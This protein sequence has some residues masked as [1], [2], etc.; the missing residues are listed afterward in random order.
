MAFEDPQL[1]LSSPPSPWSK[2]PP[3][4]DDLRASTTH[5][6]H[7]VFEEVFYMQYSLP[8]LFR[9][10]RCRTSR[11]L[12]TATSS[13]AAPTL[14]EVA[15]THGI[16]RKIDE[17]NVLVSFIQIRS[18]VPWPVLR[19]CFVDAIDREGSEA[20]SLLS[21]DPESDSASSDGDDPATTASVSG[22]G[23]QVLLE[24]GDVVVESHPQ[25]C[26]ACPTLQEYI[27]EDLLPDVLLV[28]ASKFSMY[29]IGCV[30]GW[31]EYLAKNTLRFTRVTLE[32]PD[33]PIPTSRPPRIATLSLD[34]ATALGSGHHSQVFLAPLILP[35]PMSATGPVSVTCK[36]AYDGDDGEYSAETHL[37]NEAAVFSAFPRSLQEDWSGL[38]SAK[39]D[40]RPEFM[41]AVVPKFYGYYKPS[42][43]PS[44]DHIS[45]RLAAWINSL[46]P[47]L[48]MEHCGTNICQSKFYPLTDAHKK[49]CLSLFVRLHAAGFIQ[50]SPY[51]RNITVQPGPLSLPPAARRLQTPSFRII[52]FGRGQHMDLETETWKVHGL[53]Y[54]DGCVRRLNT[55]LKMPNVRNVMRAHSYV[56]GDKISMY[57]YEQGSGA[58]RALHVCRSS[59]SRS[60]CVVLS[61]IVTVKCSRKFLEYFCAKVCRT[62]HY[63]IR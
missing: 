4:R 19:T 9:R 17:N 1:T 18:C 39:P 62:G 59:I 38:H 53:D 56:T 15:K 50:D 47:I 41:P 8:T 16:R 26:G 11:D 52:D 44:A 45:C 20:Q 32:S 57:I 42:V 13:P 22:N 63:V 58:S 54:W 35:E 37:A 3:P 51:P 43:D 25:A 60:S 36:L 30:E 40:Q 27:P 23:E 29:S 14:W 55:L 12:T 5:T 48:L 49:A 31:K 2:P 24:N 46:S 6:S 7:S 33:S 28:N 61:I 34:E 21:S 10:I